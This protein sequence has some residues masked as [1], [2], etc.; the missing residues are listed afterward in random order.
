M[1]V[2]YLPPSKNRK[3]LPKKMIALCIKRFLRYVAVTV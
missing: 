3:C 1:E 2:D